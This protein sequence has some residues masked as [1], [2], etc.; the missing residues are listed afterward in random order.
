MMS[1][2]FDGA[3]AIKRIEE[4]QTTHL[5]LLDPLVGKVEGLTTDV[6]H[7]ATGVKDL[8]TDVRGLEAGQQGLIARV[9]RLERKV[10]QVLDN[11]EI[12]ITALEGS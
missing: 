3:A 7:L 10:D 8:T 4:N 5:N 9:T 1:D 11:H 6:K 12:R 2:Q